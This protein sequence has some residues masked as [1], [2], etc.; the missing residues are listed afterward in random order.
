MKSATSNN[1]VQTGTFSM[2][3][4]GIQNAFMMAVKKRAEFIGY[5]GF[6]PEIPTP[7]IVKILAFCEEKK[8]CVGRRKS[9]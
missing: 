5:V 4:H 7:S 3:K 6:I 9:N 1:P 8:S 2:R